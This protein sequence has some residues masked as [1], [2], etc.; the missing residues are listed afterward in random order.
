MFLYSD[1]DMQY[2]KSWKCSNIILPVLLLYISLETCLKYSF[3]ET[4][5][6][7]HGDLFISLLEEEEY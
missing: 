5:K 2:L 6:S 3:S 7:L 4:L 1:M